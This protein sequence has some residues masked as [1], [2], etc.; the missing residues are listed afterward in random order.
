MLEIVKKFS[1]R[2]E[3]LESEINILKSSNLSGGNFVSENS[4]YFKANKVSG[5]FE[6]KNYK[7]R[8]KVSGQFQN[9][10][11]DY[12]KN[13]QNNNKGKN[14]YIVLN[15]NDYLFG[16]LKNLLF[17]LKSK[18][19]YIIIP[20]SEGII[21]IKVFIRKYRDY[22]IIK[23]KARNWIIF[24][25]KHNKASPTDNEVN[26]SESYTKNTSLGIN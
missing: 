17:K 12:Y 25:K 4:A 26:F 24:R 21:K 19:E 8:N 2:I 23:N 3:A 1:S 22:M 15:L 6:N 13:I 16:K 20:A 18:F 14:Y 9:K 11:K 10:F 7:I 5:S